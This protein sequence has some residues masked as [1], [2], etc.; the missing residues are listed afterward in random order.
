[1]CVGMCHQVSR[2]LLWVSLQQVR[3]HQQFWAL[4]HS[5]FCDAARHV[6]EQHVSVS[7]TLT[8]ASKV[9]MGLSMGWAPFASR[10][11]QLLHLTSS[12]AAQLLVRS[13][14]TGRVPIA[15]GSTATAGSSG[16]DAGGSHLVTN[17]VNN[18]SRGGRDSA[19]SSSHEN[20]H[21]QQLLRLESVS[22]LSSAYI[23]LCDMVND[24]LWDRTH[25]PT[26]S[27]SAASMSGDGAPGLQQQGDLAIL[28]SAL[29]QT[30]P[31]QASMTE[32]ALRNSAS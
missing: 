4:S 19:T 22:I 6:E 5:G 7:S 21:A 12:V 28:R 1:M 27:T 8:A 18:S 11:G 31:Q 30:L 20:M 32:A 24:R 14:D 10:L 9:A 26:A 29:K 15:S 3:A 23:T 13:Q 16:S 17:G 25:N 2:R